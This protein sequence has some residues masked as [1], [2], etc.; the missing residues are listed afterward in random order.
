MK[1]RM[2]ILATLLAAGGCGQTLSE[3]Y[4]LQPGLI[5]R[6]LSNKL[7][8]NGI[9]PKDARDRSAGI[10]IVDTDATTFAEF[11]RNV[12]EARLEADRLAVI[13]SELAK[14]GLGIAANAQPSP[15]VGLLLSNVAAGLDAI[16]NKVIRPQERG[17]AHLQGAAAIRRAETAYLRARREARSA[18][19]TTPLISGTKL[20]AQ[21][22]DLIDAVNSTINAVNLTLNQALANPDDL[23]T[24]IKAPISDEKDQPA[25]GQ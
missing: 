11:V 14:V 15:G 1:F 23:S 8:V 20:T 22:V 21:G 9:D 4:L 19:D 13:T 16:F 10:N 3:K 18:H 24:A 5:Q 12:L 6:S 17:V 25:G 2:L 7:I